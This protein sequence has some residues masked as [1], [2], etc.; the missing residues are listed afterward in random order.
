[1][2]DYVTQSVRELKV[3]VDFVESSAKALGQAANFD[4]AGLKQTQKEFRDR[5]GLDEYGRKVAKGAGEEAAKT[6]V[7][8]YNEK[9][10]AAK[11]AAA[12]GVSPDGRPTLRPTKPTGKG[13][14]DHSAE[15]EAKA[16]L[17]S[18]LA[19]I[20]AAQDAIVNTYAN[21]GKILEA[22]RAAGLKDEQEYYAEKKR[23]L[24]ASNDAEQAGLQQQIARLQQENLTGK[25]AIENNKKIADAQA[26]LTK[27]REDAATAVQVLAIQEESAYKKIAGAL[28]AARQ[29]AQDYFDTTNRGY[30]RSLAAQGQ[31]SKARDQ[32]AAIQ[33]IED[34][35]QQQRQ[36]LA[37]RRSQ[38]ELQSGGALTAA[39]AKQYDD[40][41]AIINEFQDK[42][43]SSYSSYYAKLDAL[44]KDWTVGASEA[45]KN[46]AD[47]AANTAKLTED[48][49]GNAFKGLED[50][51]TSFLTTGKANWKDFAN[52]VI[53]DITRM[54]VKQQITGPLAGYL[55]GALG[56]GSGSGLS[57]ILGLFGKGGGG[58]TGGSFSGLSADTL[59][60]GGYAY[61]GWTGSGGMFEPA[62]IVHKNEVVWSQADVRNAG[63]VSAVESMRRGGGGSGGMVVNFAVQGHL[64]RS[65]QTQAANKLRRV[66][67]TAT[68]RMGR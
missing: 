31:G 6:F 53:A 52:S 3:L 34:K 21:A 22:E 51:L 10:A 15:Q 45:L 56:G 36:D 41:L 38:A 13:K 5:Y 68:A 20:K 39:Q 14:A 60:L 29:A 44:Q 18:D 50:Q 66:T 67:N 37:N 59:A 26:K 27:S 4:F 43:V 42:A 11:A 62:G 32:L 35:Y 49:F 47:E 9:L 30:E 46:Y 2:V 40:Q 1:M 58:V 24:T 64:D 19:D 48:I 54:I 63:G 23:L 25:D 16:Q 17:T 61:G 7:Q 33:Q 57:S 28:L 8:A 65:T 12:N 55:G